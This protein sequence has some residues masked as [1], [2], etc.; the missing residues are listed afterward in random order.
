MNA[1]AVT[2]RHPAVIVGASLAGIFLLLFCATVAVLGST[3][4]TRWSLQ[5]AHKLI[6]ELNTE[7]I[8]GTWLSGLHAN[9][10]RWRDADMDIVLND[11]NLRVHWPALLHG[12]LK[13]APLNA[14]QLRITLTGPS[15]N[16]AVKLPSLLLP[17]DLRAPDLALQ[18]LDIVNGDSTFTLSELRSDAS[19]AGTT[20]QLKQTRLSWQD[21]KLSAAGTLS[22][23]NDYP[24]RLTGQLQMPQLAAPIA[25][26]T[27]GDLRHLQLI[28]TTTQPFAASANIVLATLD[29]NLPLSAHIAFTQ[30][31]TVLSADLPLT[32]TQGTLDLRGDLTHIDGDLK[33]GIEEPYYGAS[34]ITAALRWQ[35]EQLAIDSQLTLPSGNL[36]SVC[37]VAL[38]EA[39]TWSCKGNANAIPL[40]P[41][42]AQIMSAQISGTVSGPILLDG[43]WRQ[44][45]LSLALDIPALT[46]Q[47]GVDAI[48]G[49]L[50]L[51][52]DDA[53]QWQVPQLT[54]AAG[55][56]RLQ[57]SG[58]FGTVNQLQ[59]DVKATDLSHL[60]AEMGGTL[61]GSAIVDG[62]WPTPNIRGQLRGEHLR[63]Q[64][65][66][67]ARFNAAFTAPQA[68]LENS[69]INIDVQQVIIEQQAAFD[70]TLNSSGNREQQRSVLTVQQQQNRLNVECTTK[71]AAPYQDWQL[72]C[73]AVQADVRWQHYAGQWRNNNALRGS[74]QGATQRF[75]LLPFCLA[76]GDAALCLDSALRIDK[77]RVQAFSAHGRALPLNW[78]SVWLPETLS[79][80]NDARANL[81]IDL[82]S[83]APLQLNAALKIP[84]TQW[85]WPLAD[86]R[87][88]AA[89]DDINLAL[90]LDEL[91]AQF[92]GGAHSPTIG[93]IAAH[94]TVREPR[95]NRNLEGRV[96]LKRIELAGLAWLVEGLDSISGQLNGTVLVGG[97]AAAP[98]LHGQVLLQNGTANWAPL[99]APFRNVH[100]NLDFDNNN[101]KFGGWFS[102]GQGGGD[103]DGDASWSGTGQN[104]RARLGVIAGGISAAPLP[105]S[106]VVFSPHID[107]T[108]APNE[109]HVSGFVDIASAE[110]FLKE[111]PPETIDVS[112]D[113]HIVGQQIPQDVLNLWADIGLNLGEQ[114]HFQ[115]LGADVNLT[116]R[117]RLQQQPGDIAHLTGEVYVPQGRYRAYGQRLSVRR[118]S[119]IF[120]GPWDNPDLNLEAVRD[121][122]PGVTDVV[123]LRVIGSLKTPAA[124]LFSEP[125]LPDSDIAYYLLTG[126]K[127][128]ANAGANQFSASGALLSLGLSG[129]EDRASKLAEKFGIKDLQ[130]GT[131]QG[132]NGSEA[133]LSG[134]LSRNL[135]VRY[136][137]GLGE[138]SNTVTFQYQLTPQLMFETISG[139]ENVLDLLYSFNIK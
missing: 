14:K 111:L 108:A 56:N 96:E 26:S 10:L 103:I 118:G 79:L 63:Y 84:H 7:Q 104:W 64:T 117:L 28:A 41:L 135:Y 105:Q 83:A 86:K 94:L 1:T 137:R 21:L 52:T 45:K 65:S 5:L 57:A 131:T 38:N 51:T 102:L 70:I 12:Q 62:K 120:Y 16:S 37:A 82:K 77:Q 107:L 115:G 69:R 8:S 48:S 3:S 33:L 68:G 73:G 39:I 9:A 6:P 15:D 24:L 109:L 27:G 95:G 91:S 90:Q 119:F 61:I 132:A 66:S 18:R 71:S 89:V 54:L 110:L 75:E 4:G 134:Q 43:A 100:M 125:S 31:R 25:I 22:F 59:F 55:P 46:G 11:L 138:A 116:G 72:N 2:I 49:Q 97:N 13:V 76:G 87:Q 50:K 30:A 88:H 98:Q 101:A 36:Q 19:W 139:I 32:A 67:I 53:A 136:G 81:H 47:L 42:L 130:L 123:G 29:T 124:I 106:T 92:D 133:E 74:W 40:T 121:M 122:P 58:Q 44:Q 35:P 114:F 20:L 17:F 85:S 99:G 112:Q 34:T 113:T 78:L 93:D 80:D 126:R 128:S 129:S 127:P 60:G 23:S